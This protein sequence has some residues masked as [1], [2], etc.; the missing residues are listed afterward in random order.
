MKR[1]RLGRA[2][3][4]T[5]FRDWWGVKQFLGITRGIQRSALVRRLGSPT[6]PMVRVYF[7]TMG[8]TVLSATA[9][10]WPLIT[11]AGGKQA[12][13]V[14]GGTEFLLAGIVIMI[15]GVTDLLCGINERHPRP[16]ARAMTVMVSI[17]W[18]FASLGYSARVG[19]HVGPPTSGQVAVTILI[20]ICTAG[21]GTYAVWLAADGGRLP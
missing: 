17:V 9:A 5:R 2:I 16:L 19:N 21:W 14:L 6:P 1:I 11:G 8:V 20:F 13:E 15:G 4:G 3:M 12:A 10:C 18:G 7:W